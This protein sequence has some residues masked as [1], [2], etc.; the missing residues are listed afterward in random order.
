M[1]RNFD[2]PLARIA[3]DRGGTFTDCICTRSPEHEPIIVKVGRGA[4]LR[5]TVS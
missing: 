5:F 4:G 1:T 3:I 2:Q